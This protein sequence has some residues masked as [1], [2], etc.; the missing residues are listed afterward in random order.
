MINKNELFHLVK[1]NI[2]IFELNE[3]LFN[4]A[5]DYMYK[6]D[7]LTISNDTYEKIVYK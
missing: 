5:L 2:D 7:Y 3:E 1:N 4:K 6:M